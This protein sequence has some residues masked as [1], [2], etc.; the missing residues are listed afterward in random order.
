MIAERSLE[1]DK[2]KCENKRTTF[3]I[4]RYLENLDDGQ[5]AMN[6]SRR[7]VWCRKQEL[8]GEKKLTV[9]TITKGY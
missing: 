4:K 8:K 6:E 5:K 1:R 9:D 7:K 2:R 3:Q